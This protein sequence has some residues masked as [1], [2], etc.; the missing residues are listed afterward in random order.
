MLTTPPSLLQ[1]LRGSPEQAG[2]ERFVEMYTPLFFSWANRL[3]LPANEAADLVQ[4]V[5]AILVEQLPNFV[6][7]REKSFRAYLKTILL[8]PT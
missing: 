2:W 7:D 3:R 6:Y 8:T 5:F 4:D 1:R